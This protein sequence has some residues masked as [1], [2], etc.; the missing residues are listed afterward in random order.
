[1][2]QEHNLEPGPAF[3]ST[4]IKYPRDMDVCWCVVW[5]HKL[6]KK[7]DFYKYI[8]WTMEVDFRVVVGIR[9]VI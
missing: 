7:Y 5:T 6:L 1:M 4:D 2:K 8:Q 3:S 9:F